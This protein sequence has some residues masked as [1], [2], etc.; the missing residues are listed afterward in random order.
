ML[1]AVVGLATA[2]VR[3]VT[4]GGD[5]TAVTDYIFRGISENDGKPAGQFD[6]HASTDNGPFA[7]LWGSSLNMPRADFE[8]E[9]Y[10]GMRWSLSSEWSTT[11]T[12]VDYSYVWRG[13]T[14]S[15]D[16][17]EL[18]AA[19]SYLD[20]FTFSVAAAPNAVHYWRG[21]RLGRYPAY[22]ASV[23]AEWPVFGPVFVTA[24]AGYYYLT[25]PS[26][27]SWGTQGYAYG[28]AGVAAEHGP[29]RLDV[30]Y[31]FADSQAEN[32]F[33]YSA[34]N[35]RVAATLSWRF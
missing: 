11:L 32:L 5:L 31:Y 9:P 35:N 23:S 19:F 13:N 28:D 8:F 26:R 24:G 7:G 20:T 14:R 33:P 34:S 10:V 1:T 15:D 29:W 18:S 16:Y 22:D 6:V 17:Q 12:A 2:E 3:A 30:A 27:P 25:G 21:L 4:F